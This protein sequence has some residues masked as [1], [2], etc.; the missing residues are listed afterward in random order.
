MNTGFSFLSRVRP[1]RDEGEGGGGGGGETTSS[2][3]TGD[4]RVAQLESRL[5]R[6]M[7]AV[8]QM[9]SR[10]KAQETTE[11]I[12][13]QERDLT[14]AVTAAQQKIDAAET[15]LAQEYDSGDGA[16]YAKAQRE[17]SEAIA[18]KERAELRLDNHRAAVD[19]MKKTQPDGQGEGKSRNLDTTNL[20]TWRQ[21]NA[22]WYGV[23]QD[24]TRAAHEIHR[25]IEADR[26]QRVGSKEYFDEIDKRMAQRFPDKF[27]GSAS[28]PDTASG[29]GRAA[30]A[31]KHSNRGG[32]IPEAVADSWRRMGINMS[33][34]KVVERM[35][36]HRA[37]LVDKGVLPSD[38]V[39]D[40]VVQR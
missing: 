25:Q 37:A 29:A 3:R 7:G 40:R 27:S 5:N 20:N 26:V 4:D 19:R 14:E 18:K 33:D 17:L 16:S 28:T 21:K 11:R 32:R 10:T 15:R 34:P 13:Q 38:M 31:G 12:S 30:P 23:D 8:E 22:T 36:G 24:M 39:R 1:F 35:L 9:A 2:P 6:V